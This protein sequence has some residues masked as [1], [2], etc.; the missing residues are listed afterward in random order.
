MITYKNV[1]WKLNDITHISED[2]QDDSARVWVTHRRQER[3]KDW[4]KKKKYEGCKE[5]LYQCRKNDIL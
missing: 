2:D 1:Y 3:Y 5:H 4:V